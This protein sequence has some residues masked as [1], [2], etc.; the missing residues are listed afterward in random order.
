MA[1]GEFV[2][3][4]HDDGNLPF[5]KN[6][7]IGIDLGTTN[8]CVG[9]Y[10]NGDVTIIPNEVGKNTTPSYV[11]FKNGERTIGEQAK[12]KAFSNAKNT[13]FDAK[14]MIGRHF[15]EPKLQEIM[16]LWPFQV[17]DVN[18]KPI[19]KVDKEEFHPEEISAMIIR[20]MKKVSDI[21]LNADIKEAVIT[22]PAYFTDAQRK[23]TTHAARIAGLHL[24]RII[25]EPTAA[26]LAFEFE[27]NKINST[28]KNTGELEKK[29]VLVYDFGGG[30]FDVS[31]LSIIDGCIDT[32]GVFGDSHLGGEDLNTIIIN[33]CVDEIK[34][35][36]SEDVVNDKRAI[37]RLRDECEVAKIFLSA[38]HS[39]DISIPALVNAKDYDT[40]ITRCLLEEKIR[41]LISQTIRIVENCLKMSNVDKAEITNVILVGGSTRIPMVRASLQE[42]FGRDKPID[43]TLNADEAIAKGA[44][45]YAAKLAYAP[46]ELSFLT[47]FDRTTFS[48]G[49]KSNIDTHSVIIPR[50]KR[51][52]CDAKKIFVT[53]HDNQKNVNIDIYEGESEVATENRHLGSFV[54]TG[55]SQA[56]AMEVQIEVTF[57]I[58]N[59]GVLKVTAQDKRAMVGKDITIRNDDD[60]LSVT[61]LNNM[62]QKFNEYI[63]EKVGQDPIPQ[64]K[65]K[66]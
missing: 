22:V 32:L 9:V 27:M 54:L 20:T 26:A 40:T 58:D 35:D 16:K 12:R 37:S 66:S 46:E 43:I 15:D 61:D 56:P 25:N 42:F 59:N 52:P 5:S 45:I 30:T 3:I 13:I 41:P 62:V 64:K 8:T 50:N 1:S 2:Q 19:I 60:G 63:D 18:N 10:Q 4:D 34:R 24:L 31:I 44:S 55:I 29:K 6:I 49:I 65:N 28:K 33:H 21:F 48:L 11:A 47:L 23:A 53:S 17:I 7:V 38:S 39:H 36:L 51:I 14:R 57:N